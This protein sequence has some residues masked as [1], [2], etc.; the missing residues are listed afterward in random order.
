MSEKVDSLP[1]IVSGH[2]VERLL[3]VPKLPNGT[4]EAMANAV[5]QAWH[6]ADKV[7]AMSFDTAASNSGAV[8]EAAVL[9][10]QKMTKDLLHLA[11]RHQIFEVMLSDMFNSLAG[12]SS[13]PHIQM[14]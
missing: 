6:L 11:C 8:E 5:I 13:G 14:F 1:I 3:N 9:I 4:G 12:P 2:G 7:R 10:E